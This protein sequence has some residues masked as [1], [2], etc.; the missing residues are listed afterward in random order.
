MGAIVSWDEGSN[1]KSSYADVK[2]DEIEVSFSIG[3]YM[4]VL[5]KDGESLFSAQHSKLSTLSVSPQLIDD[6]TYIPIDAFENIRSIRV[7]LSEDRR[8]VHFTYDLLSRLNGLWVD[9]DNLE[10]VIQKKS[11]IFANKPHIF[12]F[13]NGLIEDVLNHGI[14]SVTVQRNVNTENGKLEL[15]P[16][17]SSSA[18]DYLDKDSSTKFVIESD[19]NDIRMITYKNNGTEQRLV[20]F[21]SYDRFINY[22]PMI[23]IGFKDPFMDSEKG[24]KFHA[25]ELLVK[26]SFEQ[27]MDLII[28]RDRDNN[29][30]TYI[31]KLHNSG[32]LELYEI[33]DGHKGVLLHDLIRVIVG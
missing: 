9:D 11:I 6:R 14:Y 22:L 24:T 12:S 20:R 17:P 18:T 25:K 16:I 5:D 33:V 30:E 27:D 1:G 3:G 13:S 26:E 28:M 23:A 7:E 8:V 2:L 15:Y 19:S 4:H 32:R 29:L 21:S 10:E 31:I